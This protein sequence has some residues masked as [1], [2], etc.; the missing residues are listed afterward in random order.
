MAYSVVCLG[1]ATSSEGRGDARW[2]IF[3]LTPT[4]TPTS[5]FHFFPSPARA[6]VRIEQ[7]K[8]VFVRILATAVSSR[9]GGDQ[10]GCCYHGNLGAQ[11]LRVLGGPKSSHG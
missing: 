8:M 5:L 4:Y 10:S 11:S 6:P 7:G 9:R 1:L 2:D 3:T